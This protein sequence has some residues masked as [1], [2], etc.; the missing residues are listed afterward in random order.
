MA[1]LLGLIMVD[2]LAL[3]RTPRAG[4]LIGLAAAIKLTPLIF[5]P[6]LWFAGRRRAALTAAA[7]FGGGAAVAAAA[8]PGDS[9]RFWTTEVFTVSRLGHITSVGN[10]SL[11]GALMR[12]DAGPGLRSVVVPVIGGAP[13]GAAPGWPGPATGGP[14]P[15]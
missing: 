5:I 6:L 13:C 7:T 2:V 12:L 10:Q 8:L 4:T 9:W 1:P 14:P 11:N 3:R 15:S